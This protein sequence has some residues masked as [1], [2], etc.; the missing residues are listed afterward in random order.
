MFQVGAP[1][2]FCCFFFCLSVCGFSLYI[3]MS[4]R[5]RGDEPSS[6]RLRRVQRCIIT[7]ILAQSRWEGQKETRKGWWDG[8]GDKREDCGR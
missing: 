6:G 4:V 2:V 1:C 7:A 8:E 3:C 5:K